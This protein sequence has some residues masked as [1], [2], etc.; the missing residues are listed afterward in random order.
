MTAKETQKTSMEILEVKA[1]CL[2]HVSLRGSPN[3]MVD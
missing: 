2:A 1:I 3:L